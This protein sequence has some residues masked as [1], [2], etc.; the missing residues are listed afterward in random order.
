MTF[1]LRNAAQTFQRFIDQVLRGLDCFAYVDDILVASEDLA[2]HKINLEKVFNRLKDYHLKIN[3]EKCIFGQETIQFLGFQ[4][5]PGGVSPLPDRVKALTEYPLPKS[6]AELS[7]FLAMI[8]FYYRFLKNAAGTQ[9]C[10]H[11]LV[12]G[13]MKKD[14]TPIIWTD[15]IKEAFRECKELLKDAAMLAYHKHNTPLSLV[16]NASETAIGAVLQQ[17]VE[18]GTEPLGFFPEN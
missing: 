18:G 5:S 12:K 6:V 8:N 1:D 10:L 11:D 4:V 14:K 7:R 16:T 9:A 3:L 2:K 15:E 17:H 13:R